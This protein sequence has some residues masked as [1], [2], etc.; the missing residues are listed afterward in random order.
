M[1]VHR[2]AVGSVSRRVHR[3]AARSEEGSF[4]R[5]SLDSACLTE[6]N[7]VSVFNHYNRVQA[8]VQTLE[9]EE[10]EA[11]WSDDSQGDG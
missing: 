2:P 5:V 3:R 4:R 7:C 6:L 9:V 11:G 1:F 8:N 10:D